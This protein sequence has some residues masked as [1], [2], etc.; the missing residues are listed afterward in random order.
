[1]RRNALESGADRGMHAYVTN[2]DDARRQRRCVD[3]TASH[4]V[5]WGELDGSRHTSG[6]KAS[7][8]RTAALAAL[9]G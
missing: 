9:L 2:S 6:A 1:M 5:V 8:T 7:R 4:H 3:V